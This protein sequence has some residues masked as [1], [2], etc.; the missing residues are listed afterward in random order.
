MSIKLNKALFLDRD[1][2]VIDY[3]PYLSKPEQVTLPPGAGSALYQWQ[4]AGY[5]LILI[6]NQAGVGRGYFSLT[7]V[8]AVHHCIA[9][10]YAEYGVTFDDIFLCPHHPDEGCDCRKPS[11]QMLKEAAEKHHIDLSSS[12]FLGDAPS[13]IEAAVQAGCQP[14][15]VLTGRGKETL[16]LLSKYALNIPVFQQISDTLQLLKK[17]VSSN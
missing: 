2:V 10:K 16:P 8:E 7:D 13:D 4:K 15:L 6:T 5:H 11:P 1:G 12:Y 17:E 9:Q 14:L 3:I